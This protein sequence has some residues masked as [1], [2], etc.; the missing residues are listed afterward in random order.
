MS[1]SA[2][3]SDEEI[4][5]SPRSLR[6]TKGEGLAMTPFDHPE[7]SEGSQGLSGFARN[8]KGGGVGITG[9]LI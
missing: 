7:R 1:R 5:R 4:L 8:D 6:M 3:R 9:E 2:E